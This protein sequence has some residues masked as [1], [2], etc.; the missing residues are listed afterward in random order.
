[1][2]TDF[3]GDFLQWLKGF[4]YIVQTG[5]LSRAGEVVN[6]KQSS[7][8][9]QLKKLEEN[10]GV[11][12][13]IRKTSPLQLTE[14]GKN[15]YRI[16]QNIFD[17]LKQIDIE[18]SQKD[19]YSGYISITAPY[20]IA[21]HYLPQHVINYQKQYPHVQVDILPERTAFIQRTY[22]AETSSFVITQQD[23]LPPEA[24]FI[25]IFSSDLSLIT[26]KNWKTPPQ[27]ITLE[28]LENQDF[29]GLVRELPV[30]QCVLNA[31]KEKNL[32]MNIV[33][34][35]GFFL[36]VLQYVSL[37][38]GISILDKAQAQTPGFNVDIY[39]LS[40]LFPERVYGIAYRPHQYIPPYVRNFIQ[41][42][43]SNGTH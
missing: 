21:A 35:T 36:T 3:S 10:L 8:T 24:V 11:T 42:L 28:Y 13:L 25:P 37:G 9:Y 20:G 38:V 5:S 39:S 19:N 15:L 23:L 30:D 17:N 40:H 6:R 14:E 32:S 27:E 1:M 29:I 12:L 22:T 18:V 2:V 4:Y 26:P 41:Y 16:A 31:F 34:Y 33:Q 7:I 43:Q